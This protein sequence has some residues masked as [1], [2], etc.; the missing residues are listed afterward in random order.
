MAALKEHMQLCPV[1]Q[2]QECGGRREEGA[3]VQESMST[4]AE[5]GLFE[6]CCLAMRHFETAF[7]KV[8]ASISGK[9]YSYS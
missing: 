6:E 8:K 9:V 5:V 4:K 3:G 7:S 1:G 2:R